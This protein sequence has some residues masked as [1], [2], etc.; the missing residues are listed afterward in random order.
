[1]YSP[2]LELARRKEFLQEAAHID[3][4]Q[5]IEIIAKMISGLISG[6]DKRRT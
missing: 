6:M 5:R 3:L 1:M 4:R 2:L